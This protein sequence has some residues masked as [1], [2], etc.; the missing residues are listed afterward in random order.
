MAYSALSS[1]HHASTG[2][3]SLTVT[4]MPWLSTA[5]GSAERSTFLLDVIDL[6]SLLPSKPSA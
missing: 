3:E 5:N 2:P 1:R 6:Y 4:G